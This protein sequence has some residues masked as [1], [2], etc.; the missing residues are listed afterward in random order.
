MKKRAARDKLYRLIKS[1]KIVKPALCEHCHE[2]MPLQGHHP[3][4][5]ISSG[6]MWLCS[7]CHKAQDDYERGRARALL[8]STKPFKWE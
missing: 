7:P 3:D 8:S 1:G 5:R 2:E 4:H 6:V